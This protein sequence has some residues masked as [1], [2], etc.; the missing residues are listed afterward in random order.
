MHISKFVRINL[1]GMG[2]GNGWMSPYHEAQYGEFLYQ[3]GLLDEK[4]RDTCLDME[5]ETRRLIDQGEL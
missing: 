5:A 1:A 4:E 2:V 3:F